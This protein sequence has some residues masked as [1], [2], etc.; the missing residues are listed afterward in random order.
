MR[1]E[2]VDDARAGLELRARDADDRLW[3]ILPSAGP[4]MTAAGDAEELDADARLATR[5]GQ[6]RNRRAV[7][8]RNRRKRGARAARAVSRCGPKRHG[9]RSAPYG[10]ARKTGDVNL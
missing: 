7:A 1:E 3:E 8:R 5:I 9:L 4:R 6:S 2:E 10:T